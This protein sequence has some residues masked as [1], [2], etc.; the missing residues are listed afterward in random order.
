MALQIDYTDP[1]DN[2][3]PVSYW[4]LVNSSYGHWLGGKGH[5]VVFQG[6]KNATEATVDANGTTA[7]FPI[8]TKSILLTDMTAV[9][10]ADEFRAIL[11]PE[12]K[13]DSF[14]DGSIDV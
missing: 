7:G 9:A 4:R 6:Y 12:A 14:F 11:Y 3:Y 10:D 1:N 2:N 5:S 13:T 8:L